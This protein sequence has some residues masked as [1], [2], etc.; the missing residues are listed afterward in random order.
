MSRRRYEPPQPADSQGE[1]PQGAAR[2]AMESGPSEQEVRDNQ[3][4]D[5]GAPEDA[6]GDTTVSPEE[7]DA[8]GNVTSEVENEGLEFNEE[9]DLP[10]LSDQAQQAAIASSQGGTDQYS[11][12]D[13]TA[14]PVHERN[15][16]VTNGPTTEASQAELNPAFYP[17]PEDGGPTVTTPEGE[18]KPIGTEPNVHE[19][20]MMEAEA[21]GDDQ[22]VEQVRKQ[23]EDGKAQ[24]MDVDAVNAAAEERT[25]DKIDAAT[26]QEK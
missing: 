19:R 23:I 11:Y 18:E 16:V 12:V 20:M 14:T 2:E 24:Q 26:G 8:T 5:G 6:A 25:P 15:S 21:S 10:A 13:R 3:P 1:E 22:M 17:K 7:A 4:A 9:G